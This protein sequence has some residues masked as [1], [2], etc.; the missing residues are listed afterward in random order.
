MAEMVLN[1]DPWKYGNRRLGFDEGTSDVFVG[2]T[3]KVRPQRETPPSLFS[4]W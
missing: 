3:G 2:D 4:R 1:A